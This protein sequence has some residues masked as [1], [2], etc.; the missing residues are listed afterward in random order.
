MRN[1][2]FGNCDVLDA[3]MAE[4]DLEGSDLKRKDGSA[5]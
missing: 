4:A 3:Y 2:Q 5:I 1:V